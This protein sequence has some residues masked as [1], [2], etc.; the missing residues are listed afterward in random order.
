MT[1]EYISR[2]TLLLQYYAAM[3][4]LTEEERLAATPA[5]AVRGERIPEAFESRPAA[6]RQAAL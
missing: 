1:G 5:P 4:E 6:A 3:G 2:A